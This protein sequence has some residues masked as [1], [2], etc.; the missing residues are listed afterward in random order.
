MGYGYDNEIQYKHPR[1]TLSEVQTEH[2]SQATVMM[3]GLLQDQGHRYLILTVYK[4]C[5]SHCYLWKLICLC[6]TLCS[7]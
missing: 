5:L 6:Q 7:Y 3:I 1:L 4:L 2:V